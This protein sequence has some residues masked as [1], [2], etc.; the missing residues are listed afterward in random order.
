M[1]NN[2]SAAGTPPTTPR[3]FYKRTLPDSC[4]ALNSEQGKRL[5]Q[6]AINTEYMEIYYELSTQFLTQ[7]EPAYCGLATLCM[8]L[9]ALQVDPLRK[10]KG[11]WRWYDETMLDCCRSLEHIKEKGVTMGELNCLARCNGLR[12]EMRRA[13][14][15]YNEAEDMVLILDVARFKYST[16][17]ITFDLLWESLH[18]HDS[19]TKKPRGYMVLRRGQLRQHGCTRLKV[20]SESWVDLRTSIFE[21]FPRVVNQLGDMVTPEIFL[22]TLIQSIPGLVNFSTVIENHLNLFS[23]NEQE[24][25]DSSLD[26]YIES[27]NELLKELSNTKLYKQILELVDHH[28]LI[29]SFINNFS[30]KSFMDT[31]P[32]SAI[33]NVNEFVAY[34]TLFILTLMDYNQNFYQN[35]KDP[36][37]SNLVDLFNVESELISQEIHSIRDQFSSL[38]NYCCQGC[39]GK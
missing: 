15:T 21:E 12:T 18:P 6:T 26:Q 4:I 10:W 9:N 33:S 22:K 38:E 1:A 29:R 31:F 13:D 35:L 3:S 16:Y 2:Q 19:A 8:S 25:A 37:K 11:G 28:S 5:F 7:S 30:G 17:W 32:E 39:Q 20:N 36:L 24:H 23:E 14:Q 34:L 27:L